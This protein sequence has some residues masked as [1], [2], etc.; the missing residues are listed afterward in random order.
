MNDATRRAFVESLTAPW[1]AAATN[2]DA[3]DQPLDDLIGRAHAVWPATWLS[4]ERFV[5]H[6]AARLPSEGDL[7]QS[8][9]AVRASDMFLAAACTAGHREA[10]GSF[11]ETYFAEVERASKRFT[12]LPIAAEDVGQ[13]LY[14][15]L[16][17]PDEG[18]PARI[19]QYKGHG[20]L[21][22]WVRAAAVRLM[23]NATGR[24]TKDR[25]VSDELL[26]SLLPEVDDVELLHLKRSFHDDLRSSL[27]EAAERLTYREK[28]VL[29]YALVEG[30]SIDQVGAVYGVH[31]ATAARWLEQARASLTSYVRESLKRL[32][33]VSDDEL[34]SMVR[35][36]LSKVDVTLA[37]VFKVGS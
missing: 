11:V 30:L 19:G 17:A 7:L 23:L 22:S 27:A 4:D 24:E 1:P 3:L 32:L 13:R 15:R 36:A 10:I 2:A 9:R 18:E 28:N 16:F 34:E 37:R 31:R 21:R 20:D 14:L 12:S 6:V 26:G 5:A 29:R 35:V 25:P 33:E 8:L